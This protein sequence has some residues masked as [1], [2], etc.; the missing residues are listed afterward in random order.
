MAEDL[1]RHF[2]KD[3]GMANRHMKKCSTSLS[4]R[5]MHIETALRYHLTQVRWPSLGSLQITNPGDGV[6]KREPYYT[7]CGNVNWYNQYGKQYENT[8]ENNRTTI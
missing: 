5:K 3:I 7:V 6:E 8:S 4:I 2:S 1:N